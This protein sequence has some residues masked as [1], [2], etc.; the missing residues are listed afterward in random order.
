VEAGATLPSEGAVDAAWVVGGPAYHSE[1][2]LAFCI[3]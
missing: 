2:P 1:K 3:N